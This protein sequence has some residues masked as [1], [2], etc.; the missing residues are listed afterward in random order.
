MGKVGA[1]HLKAEHKDSYK[2][3]EHIRFIHNENALECISHSDTENEFTWVCIH[4]KKRINLVTYEKI[5]K[6][7]ECWGLRMI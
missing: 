3:I 4:L 6:N 1:Y 7:L 5:L 2:L